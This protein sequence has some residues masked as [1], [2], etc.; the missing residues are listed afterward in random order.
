ML[1]NLLIVDISHDRVVI[2]E[3]DM[4]LRLPVYTEQYSLMENRNAGTILAGHF[5]G[6]RQSSAETCCVICDALRSGEWIIPFHDPRMRFPENT[7]KA[8]TGIKN[9]FLLS[10]AEALAFSTLMPED[11]R[12]QHLAGEDLLGGSDMNL[13]VELDNAVAC[14]LLSLG[15]GGWEHHRINCDPEALPGIPFLQ[16]FI[17]HCGV[18]LLLSE[19]GLTKL[20]DWVCIR[21]GRDAQGLLSADILADH[22][23]ADEETL[24]LTAEHYF[25]LLHGF[26]GYLRSILKNNVHGP[27]VIICTSRP[28]EFELCYRQ[29][30]ASSPGLPVYLIRNDTPRLYGAV[31]WFRQFLA[32]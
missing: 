29:H 8:L 2:A 15:A 6:T 31:A 12:M 18:R 32:R 9:L 10:P 4:A 1:T 25:T 16:D 13:T 5:G 24:G 20:H 7:L 3:F 21:N 27:A 28:A 22:G 11:Q 26:I 23:G 19:R 30:T 14:N 17:H